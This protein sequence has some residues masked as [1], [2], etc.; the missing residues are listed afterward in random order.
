MIWFE[1]NLIN[2]ELVKMRTLKPEQWSKPL[3]M[4]KSVKPILNAQHDGHTWR[5]VPEPLRLLSEQPEG[6]K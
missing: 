6:S 2:A 1:D 4:T 5:R 3:Q